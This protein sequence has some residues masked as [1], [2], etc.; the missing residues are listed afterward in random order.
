MPER[1][2]PEVREL[3]S[4]VRLRAPAVRRRRARQV[5][6]APTIWDLRTI[7]ARRAPRVVFDY[8]DGGADEEIAMRRSRQAFRDVELRPSVLRDVSSVSTTTQV[9]GRETA[10]PFG[11]APTDFTR[12]MHTDGERAG[13]ASAA[14][15]GIPFTLSTMGTASIEEVAAV[16]DPDRARPWFQLYLWKD[17]ARS[18]ELVARAAAAGVDTLVLTVDVP[19]GGRRLRDVRSGMSVPPALTLGSAVDAATHPSWW[20]DFVTTEPLS[21]AALD[22][23]TGRVKELFRDMF[24]A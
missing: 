10:L 7:A 11:I 14:A 24:D 19:V 23:S 17:R 2:V 13:A 6:Q 9:L 18:A 1:H 22:R 3:A 21:F 4:L 15:A 12:L 16:G 5:A 20:F 8:A